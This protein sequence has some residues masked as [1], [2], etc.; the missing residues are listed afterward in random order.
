HRGRGDFDAALP[1]LCRWL[2][3]GRH[4]REH[5]WPVSDDA[6][7]SVS[8]DCRC[9][10][11]FGGGTQGVA[12]WAHDGIAYPDRGGILGDPMNSYCKIPPMRHILRST[13]LPLIAAL[14]IVVLMPAM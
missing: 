8:H 11:W 4:R 1:G 3:A 6:V 2:A 12:Q 5:E 14:A 13:G 7:R 10:H 9:K